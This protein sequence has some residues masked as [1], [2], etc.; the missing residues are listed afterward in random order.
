M[1]VIYSQDKT[2]IRN[3]A[4]DAKSVLLSLY[5]EKLGAEAYNTM[6][7]GRIGT[8][9]RKNRGPLVQILSEKR[10]EEIRV[11]E[12]AIGMM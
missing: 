12:N 10:A 5:G 2:F 4:E 1:I 6:K 8:T 11:K 9:Y 3:D 7:N